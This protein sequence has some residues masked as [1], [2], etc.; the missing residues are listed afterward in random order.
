MTRKHFIKVAKILKDNRR[1]IVS[2][3]DN[4]ETLAFNEALNM[5]ADDMCRLFKQDNSNF[6]RDR[7]LTAAGVQE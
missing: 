2:G 4:K 3:E 7:F 5:V 1:P 6:D